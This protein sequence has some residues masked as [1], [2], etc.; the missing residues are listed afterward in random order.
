M[1][2]KARLEALHEALKTHAEF[3]HNSPE[4]KMALRDCYIALV[5]CACEAK[6]LAGKSNVDLCHPNE[7]FS[8]SRLLELVNIH[9]DASP[10]QFMSHIVRHYIVL[11]HFRVV[12]ERSGD[13]GNRFRLLNGDNGLE[14]MTPN[15]RLARVS[16][17]PDRLKNAVL[18][19][20][21]CGLITQ[22]V[23]G[24]FKL[25]PNGARRLRRS[26]S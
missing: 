24:Y 20:T 9:L 4:E 18:L 25:T 14:R 1:N 23:D 19:L 13:G 17:L 5:Y 16:V 7:R 12:Q 3:R 10:Q 22:P 8:P 26:G 11:Q 21:Q 6:N 2:P 15:G